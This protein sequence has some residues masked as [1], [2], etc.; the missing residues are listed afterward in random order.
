MDKTMGIGRE[1]R[2]YIATRATRRAAV[3]K[4]RMMN[5]NAVYTA[6]RLFP[7]LR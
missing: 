3:L 4:S 5:M 7:T 6:F 1:R 2:V